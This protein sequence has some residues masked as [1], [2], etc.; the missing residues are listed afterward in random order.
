MPKAKQPTTKTIVLEV[1][2]TGTA[3][4]LK[5]RD[6]WQN[7]LQALGYTDAKVRQVSVQVSDR[8][9]G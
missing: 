6:Q 4:D 1:E 8:T 7:A 9:K 5:K 2:T 3:R